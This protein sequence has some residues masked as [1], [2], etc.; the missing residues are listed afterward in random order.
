M[1]MKRSSALLPWILAA[2]AALADERLERLTPAH[3]AWLEEEVVY[4]ITRKEREAFL[5]IETADV[6]QRF[7]EAFWKRRDPNPATIRNEFHEEHARRLAYANDVLGRETARPGFRTDRG[8]F[9]ILLGEPREIQ[10]F[11]RDELQ[12]IELWF[13]SSDPAL[14]L[15]PSFY[16][17]FFKPRTVG[18]FELYHPTFHGPTALLIDAQARAPT[19]Q[20]ALERLREVSV[21]LAR[22]SLSF[23]PAE[24]AYQAGAISSAG[25]DQLLARIEDSPERLV[26]TDYLDAWQR[27]G[28]LVS[29]DYSFNFVPSRASFALF[30]GP[31][32]GSYVHYG[33]EIDPQNFNLETDEDRTRFDTV[34]DLDLEIRSPGGE[35]VV[36]KERE[37][38]FELTSRQFDQ[39]QASPIALQGAFPL[40][41]GD[42]HVSIIARNRVLKQY[43]VAERE[44]HVPAADAKPALSDLVLG[45]RTEIVAPG[46]EG[47]VRP[48]QLGGQLVHPAA[49]GVFALGET[50]HVLL[51]VEGADPTDV[52]RFELLDALGRAALEREARAGAYPEGIVV[53]PIPLGG[54]S[55]AGNYELQ[56]SLRDASGATLARRSAPLL[57]SPRTSVARAGFLSR[58]GFNGAA[59]GLLALE[60]AEQLLGMGLVEEGRKELERAVAAD[61][62]DLPMARW[63]LASLLINS[64]ELGRTFELLAPLEG[65][66]PDQFEV[67]AGLGFAYYHRLQFDKCRSYLERAVRLK[68]PYPAL[69]NTLADCY[70]RTGSPREALET[71]ERSLELDPNQPLVEERLSVLRASP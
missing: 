71:F 41:P 40:V 51:Q 22:A 68:A 17:L 14:G 53:E 7:I 59:P 20:E 33:I 39:V 32:G 12:P 21:E 56:A 2:S 27:Y 64:G 46:K 63:K 38:P 43:T 42:F 31:G 69:L 8:R 37:I 70:E 55:D 48:F 62:P 5:S 28:R 9:Y 50:A 44:L 4:I 65:T 29:A 3:R 6:R 25:T 15:P 30:R 10:R 1:A 18:E 47:E 34:V 49:D 16:L 54:I 35:L 61:N 36:R 45:F 23:D 26:R 13:Y 57:V 66:H 67:V 19:D 58:Q 24:R 60:R 11:D 52:L